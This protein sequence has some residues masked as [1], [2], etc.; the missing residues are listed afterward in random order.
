MTKKG[1]GVGFIGIVL[2]LMLAGPSLAQVIKLTLADQNPPQ[3]W[4]PVHALQPWIKKLEEAT[5][6]RV[7]IDVFPSQTLTKGPDTW[8]AVRVGIADMG[9]CWHGY[10]ADMTPLFDVIT[11]PALPCR[12][13][14]QGSEILWRLYER[15]PSI[16]RELRDVHPL[17]L[18]TSPPRFLITTKRQVKTMEDMR[19]LKLRIAGGPPSEQLKALG[20]VPIQM[21]MF[22][23]YQAMDKGVIDGTDSAWEAISSFKFYEVAKYYTFV[24]LALYHFSL[25]MNKQKWEGLPKEIQ[26]AITGVSGLEASKFFGRNFYDNIESSVIEQI[27]KSGFPMITYTLPPEEV[28]RWRRVA[29]EP[30]WKDWVKKMEGKGLPEAQQILNS[31]LEMFKK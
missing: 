29:G 26:E 4:G 22:D 30:I 21:A 2:V 3:G 12:N 9:W 27:K 17:M 25:V 19:G 11:L 20:A 5:K 10:W 23:I 31:T 16:Q 8:N 13:A 7:K 24:N 6:N 18:W 1:L 14:E 15:F 28:E